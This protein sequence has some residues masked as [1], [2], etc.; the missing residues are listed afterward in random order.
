M[1]K[2][3]LSFVFLAA[4][5][6]FSLPV[7]AVPNQLII[8]NKSTNQ[9][10]YFQK[11]KVVKTFSVATGKTKHATPEGKFSIANKIKNRPYYKENIR[12]G[13]KRNPLGDRWLGLKIGRT[14]GT[15]YAIHGNNNPNSIGKYVSA[16]CIRMHNEEVR[17]LYNQISVGTPVLILRS[18]QS[19]ATIA[20]NNGYSK[21]VAAK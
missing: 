15:T 10:A 5:L 20:K 13:D 1:K 8:I 16:G 11:G 17:W 14:N 12:G 21:A 2:I 6:V 3:L 7:Q 18:K 4:F 9:L 19:F